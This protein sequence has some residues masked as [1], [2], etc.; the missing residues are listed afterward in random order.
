MRKSSLKTSATSLVAVAAVLGCLVYAA[1][2]N[3]TFVSDFVVGPSG[4]W[5]ASW[6]DT[7]GG[8]AMDRWEA[9]VTGG[10]AT[11]D[12]PVSVGLT[13][14]AGTL[15]SPTYTYAAGPANGVDRTITLH[16]A[17]TPPSGGISVDMLVWNGGNLV[18]N[19]SWRWTDLPNQA[20]WTRIAVPIAESY[21]RTAVPEPTT[22]IA[23][24]LLLIPLGLSALRILRKKA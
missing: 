7:T 23:G 4:S 15:V 6:T 10:G 21:D 17:G 16:F 14:W 1:P 3:A 9:F 8:Q 11:F 13:G 12:A 5:T 2:A 18:A 19:E 20:G 22:I 24:A